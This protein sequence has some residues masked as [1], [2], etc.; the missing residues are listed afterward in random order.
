MFSRLNKAHF[1]FHLSHFTI[2]H[3]PFTIHFMEIATIGLI[4][5]V[6][7]VLVAVTLAIPLLRRQSEFG[8]DPAVLDTFSSRL[9]AWWLLFGSLVGAFLFGH[10]ITVLL[11][12]FISFWA[13]REYITL[14]RT[15]P[16]DHRAL[17]W[18]FLICLPLQ[19]FLVAV[20]SRWFESVFGITSY[21]VYSIFIPSYAFLLIPAGIA[22]SDDSTWFLE[23]VAKIEVGLLICVYSLSYVPALLT[24]DLPVNLHTEPKP[25]VESTEIISKGIDDT[26]TATVQ[27]VA[28]TPSG[29][30]ASPNILPY[31]RNRRLL[32]F[33]VLVVQLS[34]V[35]Q[36]LWSKIR[37]RHLVAPAINTTRTWEGVFGGAATTA[38][39]GTALWFFTPFP[40]WWQPGVIAFAVSFMGFAGSIT[41]SAIKRD[42]GVGDYGTLIEGHSGVLDRIDSLCFAAPVYFHLVWLFMR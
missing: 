19:F 12:G 21:Q 10:V 31:D 3:L 40:H 11:F 9:R 33:F 16:A 28:P 2:Y 4:G 17:F 14:T 29:E 41:T 24:M 32:F 27:P 39:L 35:F 36:Y 13:L 37:V 18:I 8:I 6:L 34:D 38:L 7:L 25:T 15:R 30:T 42:R 20:D 22:T 5:G 1:S 26:L 23:R